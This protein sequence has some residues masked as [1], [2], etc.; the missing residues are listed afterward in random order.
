[1]LRRVVAGKL[2][3]EKVARY[4]VLAGAFCLL[5][6]IENCRNTTFISKS[7]R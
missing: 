2:D 4:T 5:K 7:V 6:Y 3:Q 1:M